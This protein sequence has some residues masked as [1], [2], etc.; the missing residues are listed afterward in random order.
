M[1]STLDARNLFRVD[2][3]IGTD[4]VRTWEAQAELRWLVYFIPP[5]RCYDWFTDKLRAVIR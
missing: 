2:K 3:E 5:E 1:I 4:S